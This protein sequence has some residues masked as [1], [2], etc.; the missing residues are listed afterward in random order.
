MRRKTSCYCRLFRHRWEALCRLY[1]RDH[2]IHFAVWLLCLLCLWDSTMICMLTCCS[3]SRNFFPA[4]WLQNI[5][6]RIPKATSN[7]KQSKDILLADTV[8]RTTAAI[9]D[10]VSI[11]VVSL[12]YPKRVVIAL[13]LSKLFPS[14]TRKQEE[15]MPARRLRA[16]TERKFARKKGS[17][18][19]WS[20]TEGPFSFLFLSETI[21]LHFFSVSPELRRQKALSL[22]YILFF[23]GKVT[24]NE[25][26]EDT[27]WIFRCFPPP[28]RA[29]TGQARYW[30]KLL[31]LSL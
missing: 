25:R 24:L 10:A 2:K 20:K 8:S 6:Y 16:K 12:P 29:Y 15:E 11:S 7:I 19:L 28:H 22:F 3:K 31:L 4:A 14:R 30:E 5:P 23:F 17:L 27:V 21:A 18:F 1:V 9:F 13:D 26:K